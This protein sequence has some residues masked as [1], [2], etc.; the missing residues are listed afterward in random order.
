VR[1]VR[2]L[3]AIARRRP[4]LAA[5][6][7]LA[8]GWAATLTLDPWADESV[9]DLGVRRAF[10]SA[11]LAGALPYRDVAFEYP[12]LAAPVI[13]AT[14][15]IGTAPDLYRTGFAVVT[16]ALAL[17]VVLLTGRIAAATGGDARAA[18]L[19]AAAF[20]LL[21][22]AIART[23]FDL[24]PVA[25]TLAALLALLARRSTLGLALVGAATMT[26]VFPIVVAPVALAWLLARGEQRA[27]VRGGV[28]LVATIA[29]V[30]A[31][32]FALSPAGAL[33]AARYQLERPVQLESTPASVL[34]A[35][36]AFGLGEATR[37][38]SHKSAGLVHPLA[39]AVTA[40]F[41][42]ALAG[43]VCL[44]ALLAARRERARPDGRA[45]ALGAIAAVAAFAGLGKVLSPQYA[46]WLMP[47]LGLAAGW[48]MWPLATAI[49]AA[50]ALTLAEFPS[51]YLDL[52]AG[53]PLAV[54]LTG[55]RNAAVVAVVALALI[56]LRR[57]GPEVRAAS[58]RSS[59]PARPLQPR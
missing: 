14:G 13:A 42:G 10:A 31:V 37:V 43:A 17:V 5:A 58:A 16:L 35:A 52:V 27:A 23:H 44:I 26:K 41:T 57:R 1:P 56:E 45:L 29:A 51:R 2:R 54:I 12:P 49:A 20:P 50:A 34:L 8:L 25:L 4:A 36:D 24:A 38:A 15:L 3:A 7:V 48:R 47:A 22:G 30:S 18:M 39:G 11:F 19:A 9:G 21:V 59:S 32:A 55:A 46:L 33:A 40:A 53:E 28:A 6:T